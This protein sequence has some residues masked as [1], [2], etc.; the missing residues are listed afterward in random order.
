[1]SDP[2]APPLGYLIIRNGPFAGRRAVIAQAPFAIGRDQRCQLRPPDPS[3]SLVHAIIHYRDGK[4]YIQ[5]RHSERGTYVNGKRVDSVPLKAGDRLK[6]GV[7]ELEFAPAEKLAPQLNPTRARPAP[8]PARATYTLPDYPGQTSP[9][10]A[11][12]SSGYEIISSP[13]SAYDADEPAL[14]RK[15]SR[16]KRASRAWIGRLYV[17]AFLVVGALAV[18]L[19]GSELA[20]DESLT[21]SAPSHLN[22]SGATLLYFYADW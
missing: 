22:P 7:L 5:D 15:E 1:M 9:S 2:N 4:F 13:R 20:G 18:I 12:P 17:I 16:P 3:I 21:I 10:S 11:P 6:I 8:P 14:P 19:V